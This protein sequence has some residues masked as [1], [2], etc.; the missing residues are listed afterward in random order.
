MGW[1]GMR[2]D[3]MEWD[4]MA[5]NAPVSCHMMNA[6][7]VD[8]SPHSHTIDPAHASHT[9]FQRGMRGGKGMCRGKKQEKNKGK[10]KRKSE[11]KEEEE[12]VEEVVPMRM[13][14]HNSPVIAMW[15]M[16]SLRLVDAMS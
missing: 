10:G 4:G 14:V 3:A 11:T 2:C 9:C 13:D 8:A 15:D 5:C 1:D 6:C 16:V 7:H 12:E